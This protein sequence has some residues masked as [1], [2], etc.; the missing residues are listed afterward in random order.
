MNKKQ[1]SDALQ[2]GNLDKFGARGAMNANQ[3]GRS[4]ASRALSAYSK[5][6]PQACAASQKSG[7][8]SQIQAYQNNLNVEEDGDKQSII[9]N[10]LLQ[11]FDEIHGQQN[12][13]QTEPNAEEDERV[14]EQQ[15]AQSVQPPQSVNKS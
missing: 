3:D 13:M 6:R 14:E 8:A 2:R 1:P 5:K 15:E 11:K 4:E 9:T 10:E 12:N 7:M